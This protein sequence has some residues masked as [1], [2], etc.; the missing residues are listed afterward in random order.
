MIYLIQMFIT[1]IAGHFLAD[2]PLQ[3]D[4][5]AVGKSNQTQ[6]KE[7]K[8]FGVDW[9]YWMIAHA[10][11]HALVVGYITGNFYLGLLEFVLH[12]AIDWC[13]CNG[14]FGLHVDQLLH[15]TCKLSYI[16]ILAWV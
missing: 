3:N 16:V 9:F 12:F 13:K 1:L 14:R 15:A 5:I 8:H 4:A 11:T 7:G 2:F 10:A 6:E